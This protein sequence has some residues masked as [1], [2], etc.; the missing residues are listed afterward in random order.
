MF[1]SILASK[2]EDP[3]AQ[4]SPRS[5]AL[6]IMLEGRRGKILDHRYYG[7]FYKI[8]SIL[9]ILGVSNK[10]SVCKHHNMLLRTS[11]TTPKSDAGNHPLL[12]SPNSYQLIISHKLSLLA[13]H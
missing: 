7:G 6:G 12:N 10:Y 3:M 11:A 5:L 2:F 13:I 9:S 1:L 8:D 4:I